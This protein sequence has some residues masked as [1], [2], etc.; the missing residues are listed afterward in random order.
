MED[1]RKA[2]QG[3]TSHLIS[4]LWVNYNSADDFA[5]WHGSFP[6]SYQQPGLYKITIFVKLKLEF[7]L[8]Y[9][10]RKHPLDFQGAMSSLGAQFIFPDC[11][12]DLYGML[13]SCQLMA[14]PMD[15]SH[16]MALEFKTRN[17]DDFHR[18]M[19]RASRLRY[20]SQFTRDLESAIAP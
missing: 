13:T 9:Q 5:A 4:D 10:T 20:E 1:L 11:S 15:M 19:E 6:S 12:D 2:V 8:Q 17:L 16:S 7:H 14:T 3:A 18:D